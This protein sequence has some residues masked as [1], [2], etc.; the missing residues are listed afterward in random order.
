MRIQKWYGTKSQDDNRRNVNIVSS[1][2]EFQQNQKGSIFNFQWARLH[3]RLPNRTGMTLASAFDAYP[4]QR[5]LVDYVYP[6][7][8]VEKSVEDYQALEAK[9]K[10]LLS[11]K[12]VPELADMKRQAASPQKYPDPNTFGVSILVLHALLLYG[13]EQWLTRARQAPSASVA[14]NSSQVN[15]KKATDPGRIHVS[16]LISYPVPH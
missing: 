8:G 14:A 12:T 4:D 2:E 9:L 1:M 11:R 6:W 13:L 3:D 16:N 10:R 15:Q 7:V 5:E